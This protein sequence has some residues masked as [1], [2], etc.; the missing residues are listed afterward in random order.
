MVVVDYSFD[1]TSGPVRTFGTHFVAEMH[2]RSNPS[3]LAARR[4]EISSSPW[5]AGWGCAFALWCCDEKTEAICRGFPPT[6]QALL[7][8]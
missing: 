1:G 8:Q 3:R 6:A 5:H 2:K 4:I 7:Q